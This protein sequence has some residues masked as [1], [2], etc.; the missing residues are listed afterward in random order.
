M[1]LTKSD[2]TAITANVEFADSFIKQVIGLMFRKSFNGVLIFDMGRLTYDGIHML[3]VRFPIDVVFLDDDKKIVDVKAHVRPWV[4][5]AFPR[6]LF[7]YAIE[8]PAGAIERFYLK[9]G[10]R[11]DW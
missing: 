3:F 6:S 11:L 9:T 1:S 5:T 7:R 10:E 2:G 4:G 8:L